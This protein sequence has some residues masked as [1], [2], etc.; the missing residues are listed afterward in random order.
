MILEEYILG[1]QAP[2]TLHSLLN[3]MIDDGLV[4]IDFEM[5]TQK[6]DYLRW[7]FRILA[8]GATLFGEDV[9]KVARL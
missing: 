9:F 1:Q 7:Q 2:F 5:L 4:E 3:E 6:V 8:T